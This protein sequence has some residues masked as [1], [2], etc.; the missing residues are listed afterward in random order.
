MQNPDAMLSEAI[1]AQSVSLDAN[2]EST[3]VKLP[4]DVL[5]YLRS[6]AEKR[7]VSTGDMVRIALGT[8]KFL[9]DAVSNGAK[10]QLNSKGS[11]TDV[12][13]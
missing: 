12:A 6:T 3:T 10:V 1:K 4:S 8:Q 7:G 2:L 5:E 9:A 11:T 13:I